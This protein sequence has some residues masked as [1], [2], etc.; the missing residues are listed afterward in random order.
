M[1]ADRLAGLAALIS[2][3][4][5]HSLPIEEGWPVLPLWEGISC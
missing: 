1:R 3:L 2:Y 4:L 5:P